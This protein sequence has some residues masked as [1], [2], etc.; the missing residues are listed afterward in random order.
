MVLNRGR[1]RANGLIRD[2]K[3]LHLQQYEVRLKS[4]WEKYRQQLAQMGCSAEPRDDL[5]VV[6]VPTGGTQALLWQAAVQSG[7]QIRFLR[8]KRGT[9]EEIFLTAVEGRD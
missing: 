7:E 9:L 8:P 4:N 3:K 1:L 5:L 6:Q 2:L